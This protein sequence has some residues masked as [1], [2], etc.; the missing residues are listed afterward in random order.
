MSMSTFRT[1]THSLLLLIFAGMLSCAMPFFAHAQLSNTSIART[2][3]VDGTQPVAGDLVSFDKDKQIL[4]LSDT[5][6]DETLFGVVVDKPALVLSSG[7]GVP[8][9]SSGEVSV[10]VTALGGPIAP[11]DYITTSSEPGKGKKASPQ[12]GFIVGTA[13]ESFGTASSSAASG[14][15]AVHLSIGARPGGGA[16]TSTLTTTKQNTSQTSSVT[17][18]AFVRY[19]LAGLVAIGSIAIA[20]RSFGSSIKESIVSVGRN[21]LAKTS[22]QSMVVLNTFLIVLVSAAG[23]FVA[24]AILFVPI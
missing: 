5:A 11:G 1:S 10:N 17:I 15:I 24:F 9:I 21:P 3:V 12:D 22:I 7:S 18:P 4:H 2:Y 23:L 14:A 20:F 19:F 16:N 6:D 8:I 13:L